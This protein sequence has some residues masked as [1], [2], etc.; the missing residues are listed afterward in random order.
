M[1]IVA[2]KIERMGLGPVNWLTVLMNDDQLP[3]SCEC[4]DCESFPPEIVDENR[5]Y[6]WVF[7]RCFVHRRPDKRVK[8]CV[9]AFVNSNSSDSGRPE[10]PLSFDEYMAFYNPG[11]DGNE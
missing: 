1:K 3:T 4:V 11:T 9:M 10:R 2:Q 6:G 5:Q 7:T 8:R